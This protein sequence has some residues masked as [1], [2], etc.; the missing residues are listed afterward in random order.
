MKTWWMEVISNETMKQLH[1][2]FN[3]SPTASCIQLFKSI[4]GIPEDIAL[5]PKV[6]VLVLDSK[7]LVLVLTISV[8]ETSLFKRRKSLIS[9][10]QSP[11]QIV[12]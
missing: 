1:E 9:T 5:G 7:L 12:S 6:L 11:V 4:F 2:H 8:F 10:A 3:S